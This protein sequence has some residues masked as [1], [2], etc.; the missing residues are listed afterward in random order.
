MSNSECG[1]GAVARAVR[2]RDPLTVVY[3][4]YFEMILL[5]SINCGR[6]ESFQNFESLF[7]TELS[8]FSCIA[9]HTALSDAMP[10]LMLLADASVD[11]SQ[12][13]SILAAASLSS[14]VVVNSD[15]TNKMF[16]FL[17]CDADATVMR[18]CDK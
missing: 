6:R 5:M 17:H 8:P 10:A 7:C 1:I 16:T 9:S 12:R 15:S 4:V 11:T 14:N 2:K 3:N 18:K 13:A